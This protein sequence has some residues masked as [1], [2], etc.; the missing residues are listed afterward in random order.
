MN[1]VVTAATRDVC[2]F[3]SEAPESATTFELWYQ[4]LLRFAG[5]MPLYLLKVITRSVSEHGIQRKQVQ[6][7]WDV[8]LNFLI[9]CRAD[10]SA[11][12]ITVKLM[13]LGPIVNSLKFFS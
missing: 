7:P 9:S 1:L 5:A 11:D 6:C 10:E 8:A 3:I 12:G 4:S 13:S 2:R